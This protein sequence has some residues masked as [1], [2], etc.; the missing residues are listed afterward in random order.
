M[1]T[2]FP[3]RAQGQAEDL[4]ETARLYK[5]E[6]LARMGSAAGSLLGLGFGAKS[7]DGAVT[8]GPAIRVYVRSKRPLFELSE[9]E[10]IPSWVNG[11]PT[12]VIALGDLAA[13]VRPTLCGVS[14]G[15]PAVTAGTLGCLLRRYK[16][17][18]EPTYILSNNHVLANC[19][20]AAL[21][22]PILEP[23]LMDG[24]DPEKPIGKLADFEPLRFDGSANL[25][26]AAI[27][28]VL[29]PGEVD[30]RI[31]EIGAVAFPVMPPALYQAVRKRGRTT[32]H[33]LGA[34]LDISADVR[35]RYDTRFAFFEDQIAISGVGGTFSDGGDSGA[36][37]VDA[38]TRRPVA[39]LFGGGIDVT[40][41]SPI[42]PVLDRFGVE[43][44]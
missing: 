36:L 35:V 3:L 40:F 37:I 1:T 22:D 28:R 6:L 34:I 11:M 33:T 9:A 42:Q 24:G 7:A 12:D 15:H 44:L 18:D 14:I 29:V 13:Q 41:A 38:V 39:L 30:P 5:R 23:A 25:F 19:N 4:L 31:L 26:D 27:A 20:D 8:A 32:L 17:G 43:I 16:P 2:A 10:A 21:E